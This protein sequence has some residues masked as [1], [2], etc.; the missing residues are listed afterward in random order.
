M[1]KKKSMGRQK[2]K[3]ERIKREDT[4]Q[5]TFSK[6]RSGL[7]KKASEMSTLCG[8]ETAIVV[9]S[10]AGK[11]FSFG[12]PSVD[13]ILDRFLARTPPQDVSAVLPLVEAHRAANVNELNREYSEVR[14]QLEAEKHR[15]AALLQ[16]RKV[17][18]N[19]FWWKAPVD[20]LGL[21]E[22]QQ[23]KVSMEELKKNIAKRGEELFIQRSSQSQFLAA[24][25]IGFQSQF[26]AANSVGVVDPFIAQTTE[27]NTSFAPQV[28]TP[29]ASQG[30]DYGT[31]YGY[32][33]G[34]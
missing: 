18:Q 12:H 5:V 25:S 13:T 14:N 16:M 33:Y 20:E 19:Q 17:S 26:L 15:G 2:I 28:I 27:A 3:I 10:P 6:R 21:Y 31:N 34:C 32:G 11:A 1:V 24:N 8:V 7:F 30:Y 23:L 29:I 9:F 22:L 4:R